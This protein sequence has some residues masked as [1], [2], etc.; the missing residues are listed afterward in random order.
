MIMK[1]KILIFSAL[2]ITTLFSAAESLAQGFE[3]SIEFKKVSSID[4][5][6]YVYYIKGDQVRIDEIGSDKHTAGTMLVNIK[7]GT[8]KSLSP[9]R[10]LYLDIEPNKTPTAA[11]GKLQVSKGKETKTIAGY[12]CSEITVKDSDANT[13]IKYYIAKDNFHF[14]SGVIKALN[15]KDKISTYYL[16]L[17]DVDN[18]FPFYAI[19][20]DF[21]G[22][23]KTVLEVTTVNKH[24]VDSKVFEIPAGYK[25]FER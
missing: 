7:E 17:K 13:I 25:K 1:N 19:E 3:G 12:K 5:I 24:K 16:Q 8:A 9:E 15:R 6:T 18:S 10:K 23:K 14:L 20:T 22:N 4:T 21:A 11:S 2:L